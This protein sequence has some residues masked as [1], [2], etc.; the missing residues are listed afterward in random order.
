ML[1]WGRGKYVKL[2]TAER[3]RV[4]GTLKLTNLYH[5]REK[6]TS[7][8][9]GTHAERKSFLSDDAMNYLHRADTT[10]EQGY[11]NDA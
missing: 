6:T 1:F 3:A 5:R 7:V 8:A 10:T 9:C 11:D 4:P 2:F